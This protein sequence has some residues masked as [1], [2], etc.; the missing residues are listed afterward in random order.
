MVKRWFRCSYLE[1]VKNLTNFFQNFWNSVIASPTSFNLLY[2]RR[3]LDIYSL[4]RSR[5]PLKVYCNL[6]S[7]L[8]FFHFKIVK[9]KTRAFN[10]KIEKKKFLFS[11]I[12]HILLTANNH[13]WYCC[14]F[15]RSD[16]I[17]NSTGYVIKQ[18][19]TLVE[20]GDKWWFWLFFFLA[21]NKLNFCVWPSFHLKNISL[22]FFSLVCS[23][24]SRYYVCK[25]PSFFPSGI[26]WRSIVKRKTKETFCFA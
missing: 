23:S 11:R 18:L 5:A 10:R 21:R 13:H 9:Y 3:G 26:F 25:Q 14:L 20:K 1:V 15:F 7:K 4:N 19:R 16:L 2:S 6:T 24:F 22:Y 8:N 12:L 17:H